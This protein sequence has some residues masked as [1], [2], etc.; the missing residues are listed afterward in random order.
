MGVTLLRK[1]AHFPV[2]RKHKTRSITVKR[3]S[4]RVVKK[5]CLLT[6]L[7]GRGVDLGRLFI[8]DVTLQMEII[9]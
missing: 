9:I 7:S 6:Y 4:L 8:R 5:I 1:M 2:G 3:R